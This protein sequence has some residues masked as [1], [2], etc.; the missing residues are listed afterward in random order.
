MSMSLITWFNEAEIIG[1]LCKDIRENKIDVDT[2]VIMCGLIG[3]LISADANTCKKDIERNLR[4]IASLQHL[5]SEYPDIL[6][7]YH[8]II[9]DGKEILERDYREL[10]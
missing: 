9:I 7:P 5:E 3:S 8:D 6:G 1:R 2:K 4:V 10:S